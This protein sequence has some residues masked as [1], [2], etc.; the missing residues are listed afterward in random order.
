MK[1]IYIP[2]SCRVLTVGHI[3]VLEKLNKLGWVTVGLLTAKALEGY[4]E[5]VVP[6]E[7]RFY[8]LETIAMALGNVDVI[9]QDSLDPSV[10]LKAKKYDAFASGDGFEPV[11]EAAIKKF[12]LEKINVK[13]HGEKTKL[14]SSSKILCESC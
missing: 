2:M 12:K 10:N 8:I 13:L 7:D 1:E 4:K 14:Y 11:E 9:P 3:K 5:E 6:Y